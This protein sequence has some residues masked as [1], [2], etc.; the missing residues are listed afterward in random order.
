L[1]VELVIMLAV[2]SLLA[3]GLAMPPSVP[4]ACV[5]LFSCC[6]LASLSLTSEPLKHWPFRSK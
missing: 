5:A 4:G 1:V 2:L 3:S 6:A